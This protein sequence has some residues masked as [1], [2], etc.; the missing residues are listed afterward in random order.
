MLSALE[1]IEKTVIQQIFSAPAPLGSLQKAGQFL[2]AVSLAFLVIGMVFLTYGVHAW[3]SAQYSNDI[4]ILITG[5]LSLA[6]SAVIAIA[7]LVATFYH[8]IRI[9][10]Y[11]KKMTDKIKSLLSTVENEFG[12]PVRENPKTA[13]MIAAIVGFLAEDQLFEYQKKI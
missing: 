8:K 10:R 1:L 9:R 3:L 11:Q 12:D 5:A 7:L 2:C 13:L 6:I 4:A